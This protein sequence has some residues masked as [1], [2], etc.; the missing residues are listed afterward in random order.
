MLPQRRTRTFDFIVFPKKRE[1][2]DRWISKIRRDEGEYF[3]VTE[4]TRICSKHF[5]EDD[6]TVN[7]DGK[8]KKVVLK[9]GAVPTVFK[10]S[11]EKRSRCTLVSKGKRKGEALE[12]PCCKK[13]TTKK[14][15]ALRKKTGCHRQTSK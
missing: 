8:G 14:L 15:L 4:N 3:A 6:Y 13:T 12:E 5:C 10:W 9:K 11:S 2:K 1:Q 7:E